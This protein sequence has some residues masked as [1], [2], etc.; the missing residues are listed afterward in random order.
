MNDDSRLDCSD[1]AEAQDGYCREIARLNRRVKELEAERLV[2]AK[3]T[4]FMGEALS[5]LTMW[6]YNP[7]EERFGYGD[8][9]GCNM[10]LTPPENRLRIWARAEEAL[11][12]TD[13]KEGTMTLRGGWLHKARRLTEAARG[14]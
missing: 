10:R 2:Y 13:T 6:Y 1:V 5:W 11:D 14:E 9:F 4:H 7:K 8:N 3:L 12:M